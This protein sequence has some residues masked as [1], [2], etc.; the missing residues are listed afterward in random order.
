MVV[1]EIHLGQVAVEVETGVNRPELV[2]LQYQG[3]H[4][5]VQRDRHHLKQNIHMLKLG[6]FKFI[7]LRQISKYH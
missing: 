4:A 2:V 3:L 1:G 5:G 7:F 6:Y